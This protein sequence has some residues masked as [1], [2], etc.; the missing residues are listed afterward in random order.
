[1]RKAFGAPR[2]K[3]IAARH[4]PLVPDKVARASGPDL[5]AAAVEAGNR[6]G[7]TKH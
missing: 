2:E 1:M 6:I 7:W 5:I 3:L 4:Y